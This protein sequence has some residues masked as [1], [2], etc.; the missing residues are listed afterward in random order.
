M[1]KYRITGPDGASYEITAPDGA[2]QDQVLAYAQQ[3]FGG[4]KPA[5]QPQQPVGAD[6]PGAL[7]SILIGAGR[8][9][10]NVIDGM[11]QL[12]FTFT[13]NRQALDELAAK[14]QANDK[15]YGQLEKQHPFATA[16]G[17]ALPGA[18][19]P[20]GGGA[21]MASTAARLAAAGAIPGALEYGTAGERAG[22][23]AGGA[24]A[25]VAGGIAIPKAASAA[26]NAVTALGRAA[27]AAV[28]PFTESG[29]T[30]IAGRVLNKAAGADAPQVAA[31]LAEVGAPA[32]GPFQPGMAKTLAGELVPGSIPTV[33]Q[34]AENGGLAALERA[35]AAVQPAAFSQRGM[36]QAAARVGA[37]RGI[38]GD[39]ARMAAAA[40]TRSA[41]S[42]PLYNAASKQTVTTADPVLQELLTRPSVQKAIARAEKI[43]AEEGRTFGMVPGRPATPGPQLVDE[44]GNV[45]L[46]LGSAAQP[47][48]ITGQTLQDIKMG[49]DALL[50]DPTSGIA[51]KEA[52]LLQQT[53][54]QLMNWMENAIPELRA[55]RQTYAQLSRPINQMQVGQ[56][57]VQQLEP[58][59]NDYGALARET[60]NKYA[61]ALRNADQTART[62]TK[63]KGAGMQDIMT[64]Q[65]MGTLE[66]VAGDLARKANAENLGRGVG[67][68][69]TQKLLLQDLVRGNA[70]ERSGAPKLIAALP[71]IAGTAAG[72]LAG[73]PV[74]AVGGGSVGFGLGKVAKAIYGTQE[75]KIVGKIADALL[76]PGTAGALM[77][78]NPLR[79]QVP[80]SQ[81]L[82]ANPARPTQMLG[83]LGGMAAGNLFAQ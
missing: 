29:R 58:A 73:G 38:A 31:R 53:R 49:M 7:M 21:T 52:E 65:Q 11:K 57:L 22:R 75:E 46:D 50:K 64:P 74:G 6:D 3:H 33:G 24:A 42:K 82:L 59:L 9:A 23:A 17:E 8:T 16:V 66:G 47:G 80:L 27:R 4:Q 81:V 51:G 60:G 44:A 28:E 68:D 62:A 83:G 78:A 41:V 56:R 76:D 20:A 30:A 77:S 40:G 39:E 45:L 2:T 67:S 72:A 55:A 43:A 14:H 54:G 5:A 69:T 18:V 70:A 1:P 26:V 36:E 37:L 32:L 10:D 12:G 34:V 19:I 63:F 13:G 35:T 71:T 48:K 61:L 79:P 25:A 15:A